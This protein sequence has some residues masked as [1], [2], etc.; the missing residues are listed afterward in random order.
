MAIYSAYPPS[1]P[2]GSTLQKPADIQSYNLQVFG[3]MAFL[4]VILA[5]VV[6]TFVIHRKHQIHQMAVLLQ[7]MATLERLLQQRLPSKK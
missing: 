3:F 5:S 2:S 6:L 1:H 4:F 7:R